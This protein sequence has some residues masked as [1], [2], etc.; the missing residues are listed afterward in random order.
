[1]SV[2]LSAGWQVSPIPCTRWLP[3]HSY[4]N[5]SITATIYY[6]Q[7]ILLYPFDSFLL[8]HT[9]CYIQLMSQSIHYSLYSGLLLHTVILSFYCI[10]STTSNFLH[11]LS[12]T[13][14]ILTFCSILF[15]TSNFL[16]SLLSFLP[17]LFY[18][19]IGIIF[20]IIK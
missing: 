14:F 20:D 4:P 13:Q 7:F 8:L 6:T 10:L 19:Y 5:L 3:V 12:I 9:V 11:S 1:M 18:H 17:M 2:G 16:H 15:I